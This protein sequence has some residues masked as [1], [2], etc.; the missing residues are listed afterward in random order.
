MPATVAIAQMD[1]ELWQRIRTV[2]DSNSS[3]G[4]KT[5]LID[6]LISPPP[7]PEAMAAGDVTEGGKWLTAAEVMARTGRRTIKAV[8]VAACLDKWR[9]KG[10]GKGKKALY[11]HEDALRPM[12]RTGK[13][14]TKQTTAPIVP[15]PNEPPLP[16]GHMGG[17]HSEDNL[18]KVSAILPAELSIGYR[19]EYSPPQTKDVHQHTKPLDV[20][21]I[22]GPLG[23]V[24]LAPTP[25]LR[26]VPNTGRRV[27]KIIPARPPEGADLS[28]TPGAVRHITFVKD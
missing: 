24:D 13:K 9:K 2:L 26:D 11:W 21:G 12:G 8:Q 14:A 20:V 10:G 25:A 19:V 16:F 23:K 5:K 28:R 22:K 17:E 7:A 18:E 1:A 27:E 15:D 6:T 3:S 4:L